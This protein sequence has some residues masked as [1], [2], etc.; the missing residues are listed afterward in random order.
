MRPD[1]FALARARSLLRYLDRQDARAGYFL[2]L[3]NL[4]AWGEAEGLTTEDRNAAAE[5]CVELGWLTPSDSPVKRAH[6]LTE[7]G[8]LAMRGL[9]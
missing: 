2:Y 1:I 5:V 3:Q 8:F 6:V 4:V 9:S 7:D